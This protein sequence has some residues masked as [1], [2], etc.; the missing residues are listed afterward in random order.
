MSRH[1]RHRRGSCWHQG[2]FLLSR[3]SLF[4]LLR[5]WFGLNLRRLGRSNPSGFFSDFGFDLCSLL[6]SLSLDSGHLSSQGFFLSSSCR[7]LSSSLGFF[8]C[9]SCRRLS[10]S[11]GF[12]LSSSF[13]FC[14][15]R[16]YLLCFFSNR[17]FF[18]SC[19]SC[20]LLSYSSS[21]LFG[22]SCFFR[23]LSSFPLCLSS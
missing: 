3:R 7:R 18:L 6:R 11:L 5:L 8:L 17:S 12:F 22:L 2:T 1:H 15:S 20:L 14:F 19:S 9:C 21:F 23:S 4:H 13:C 16:S 10:S